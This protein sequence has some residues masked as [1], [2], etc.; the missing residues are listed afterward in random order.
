MRELFLALDVLIPLFFL[1][2]GISVKGGKRSALVKESLVCLVSALLF[3]PIAALFFSLQVQG[4]VCA[5]ILFVQ[6]TLLS[7]A[8]FQNEHKTHQ[9]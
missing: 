5:G 4:M 2:L 8:T 6:G 1:L 9:K 3:A 7:I